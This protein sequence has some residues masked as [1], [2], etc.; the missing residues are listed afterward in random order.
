MNRRLLHTY[1]INYK[2][3]FRIVYRMNADIDDTEDILQEVSIKVINNTRNLD[4][5]QL[6]PWCITVARNTAIDYYRKHRKRLIISGFQAE[7]SPETT[8]KSEDHYSYLDLRIIIM[9]YLSTL[10]PN[11]QKSLYLNLFENKS[12]KQ[13]SKTINMDYEKVR[14]II[15][16][17]KKQLRRIIKSI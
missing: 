3:L 16:K 4:D 9:D 13:I 10:E 14:H 17:E 7:L 1:K 5:K 2:L 15:W 6:L 12:A 8:D 11:I